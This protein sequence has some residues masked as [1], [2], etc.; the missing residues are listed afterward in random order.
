[1]CD[2][3]E[4]PVERAPAND[5]ALSIRHEG[6]VPAMAAKPVRPPA[7]EW[8]H[9]RDRLVAAY[10]RGLLVPFLGAGM[11]A[12]S[13]GE[14][15][16]GLPLW[17]EF[18]KRLEKRALA[19]DRRPDYAP[20]TGTDDLRRRAALAVRCLLR[21]SGEGLVAGVREALATVPCRTPGQ[22]HSLAQ[23]GLHWP[24][25]LTTNYDDLYVAAVHEVEARGE[26][27]GGK[28]ENTEV[29]PVDLLG[30][31]ER[32]CQEVL[33]SLRRPVRPIL[34]ALQ[35]FVG[36]QAKVPKALRSR[37]PEESCY[38]EAVRSDAW[39]GDQVRR[40]QDELVVGHAE[41]RRVALKSEAF[42]RAFAEVYRS[43][44][45]LFLGSSLQDS[46]LLDLFSEVIELYGPSPFPHFAFMKQ[47]KS[48]LDFLR[49]YFGIWVTE[50]QEYDDL[51]GCLNDLFEPLTSR[52]P[53]SRQQRSRSMWWHDDYPVIADDRP[54]LEVVQGDLLNAPHGEGN[55]IVVS[56]GGPGGWESLKV[57]EVGKKWLRAWNAL[58]EDKRLVIT[59]DFTQE[60]ADLPED[61]HE[62]QIPI[63]RH[64]TQ[65]GFFAVGARMSPWTKNGQRTR[66]LVPRVPPEPRRTANAAT[67][68]DVRLVSM[69]TRQI[70][71][72]VQKKNDFTRVHSMLLSAGR[73]RT[74]PQSASLLQM[75]RGWSRFRE[76]DGA[77]VGLTI[78]VA[79]DADELL[80]DLRSGR[81]DL[82]AGLDPGR[83]E[84]WVEVDAPHM[85]YLRVLAC[86]QAKASL[87]D[88]AVNF[89]IRSDDWAVEVRPLPGLGFRDWTVGGVRQWEEE[90]GPLMDLERFGIL[91]GSI[92]RF[93]RTRSSAAPWRPTEGE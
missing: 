69:A 1:M 71:S 58:P 44:S 21:S 93:S 79:P 76:T 92:L 22:L 65:P 52:R 54:A 66:P 37:H 83:L 32:D 80:V 63:I 8:E 18:V 14:A 24:L 81:L 26:R 68:R 28:E 27:R 55:C 86:E 64:N 60:V 48:D 3:R 89:D 74:F 53:P 43:R 73:G 47:G 7:W 6:T 40:L 90:Q 34:W 75:I 30:R 77:S 12:A 88:V 61:L 78:Y 57:S 10:R 20:L 70:L 4:E 42:R 62:H 84:F 16:G 85:P 50:I 45:L 39:Y 36:G 5:D 67:M 11:S 31:S 56:A 87:L 9:L 25:V 2:D 13:A 51:P 29:V 59:K 35:G 41:Y 91:P 33:A 15:Q 23:T 72:V 82:D 38:A 46:Y 19:C 49:Q 17:S